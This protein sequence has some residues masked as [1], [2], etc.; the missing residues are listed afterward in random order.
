MYDRPVD[1]TGKVVT[2][3][4]GTP[5]EGLAEVIIGKQRNGPTGFARMNFRKQFTRFENF[6]PRQQ[7]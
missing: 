5:I 6:T 2:T 4:D 7:G 1:E 3:P